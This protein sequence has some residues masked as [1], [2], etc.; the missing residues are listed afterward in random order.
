MHK[1]LIFSFLFVFLVSCQKDPCE[2][3]SCQNGGTCVDGDCDCPAG[4]IG[5]DCGIEL[6][7]CNQ[8]ACDDQGTE[9]CVVGTNGEARCECKFGYEGELCKTVWENKFVGT[10][11]ASEDCSGNILNYVLEVDP[12]PDPQQITFINFNN[13]ANDT[14]TAKVVANLVNANVFEIYVQYMP[15]GRV[16]GAGSIDSEGRINWSFEIIQPDDTLNCSGL[17]SPN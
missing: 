5:P 14:V 4:F 11:I 2:N 15:F 10:Y 12:G 7:P 1:Y 6:N 13:Q 17:L 9:N 3:I 8:K 16:S